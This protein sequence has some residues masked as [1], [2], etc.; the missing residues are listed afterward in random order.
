MEKEIDENEVT[1]TT[2]E[3]GKSSYFLQFNRKIIT[4]VMNNWSILIISLKWLESA[5]IKSELT[6]SGCQTQL[7][8]PKDLVSDSEIILKLK[9]PILEEFKYDFKQSSVFRFRVDRIAR[10]GTMY[11]TWHIAPIRKSLQ[12]K[13]EMNSS[14]FEKEIVLELNVKEE[15][16]LVVIPPNDS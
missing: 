1:I 13:E 14:I 16:F 6:P 8:L 9:T 11:F 3:A 5:S 12:D 4:S 2:K 15:K 7:I 10:K